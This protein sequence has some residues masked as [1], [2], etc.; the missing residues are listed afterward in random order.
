M[1]I[2]VIFQILQ[3]AYMDSCIFLTLNL[4]VAQRGSVHSI[5]N[6]HYNMNPYGFELLYPG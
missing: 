3:V 5:L 2:N 1:Q 6:L 4:H